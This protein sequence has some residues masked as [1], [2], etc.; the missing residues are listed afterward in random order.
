LGRSAK[1]FIETLRLSRMSSKQKYVRHLS[2]PLEH[3][4]TVRPSINR[5]ETPREWLDEPRGDD[6]WAISEGGHPRGPPQL[7]ALEGQGLPSPSTDRAE[8]QDRTSG[9]QR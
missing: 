1:R 8:A 4:G 3:E 5:Q 9:S 2:H 6:E 7:L